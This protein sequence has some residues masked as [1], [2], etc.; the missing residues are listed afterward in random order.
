MYRSVL[1]VVALLSMMLGGCGGG[2]GAA[3]GGSKLTS[4]NFLKIERGMNH[5]DVQL[6]LGGPPDEEKGSTDLGGR[7]L[8]WKEGGKKI[9]VI[10]DNDG[11][12]ME[13]THEG[14]Q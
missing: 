10:I 4:E 9:T 11:N 3:D 8:I 13:K 14:L 5:Q 1:A 12:V 2:G 7:F 6:I